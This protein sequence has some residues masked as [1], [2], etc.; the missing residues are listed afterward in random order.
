MEDGGV[1][2]GKELSDMQVAFDGK[3]YTVRS[4][5]AKLR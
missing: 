3:S 2:F 4:A 5:A 1:K